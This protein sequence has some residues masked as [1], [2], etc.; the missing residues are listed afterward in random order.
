MGRRDRLI[1]NS[2]LRAIFRADAPRKDETARLGFWARI[3]AFFALFNLTLARFRASLFKK[4]RN[5]T[6]EMEE[7][8]YTE[9]FRSPSSSKRTDLVAIGDLG[10]SGS[11]RQYERCVL[12]R[13]CLLTCIRHSSRHQTQSS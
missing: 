10:Y 9:S 5:D 2:I 3:Y 1:S 4:L 8:E 7:E 12:T 11:V 6:W 13:D